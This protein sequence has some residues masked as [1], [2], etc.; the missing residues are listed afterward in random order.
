[1]LYPLPKDRRP[2]FAAG[3]DWVRQRLAVCVTSI[4][5]CAPASSRPPSASCSRSR[6]PPRADA[7]AHPRRAHGVLTAAES[8]PLPP[9]RLAELK[10]AGTAIV[11][12][13]HRVP[14]VRRIADRITV[15]RDGEGRGTM[16]AAGVTADDIVRLIVGR[17]ITSVF[18]AKATVEAGAAP[19]L[20]VADLA[21]D[22]F[23][24]A[25]LTVRPGGIVE[26]CGRRGERPARGA[27]GDR[28]SRPRAGP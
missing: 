9:A 27:A 3:R 26:A 11:Y 24:D 1:M 5:G 7:R 14:E 28:R 25:A 22:R 21:G 17:S 18:P 6:G 20:Q 13:S 12:I 2:S 4:R 8:A 23:H 16:P 15:L 19:I 10:A